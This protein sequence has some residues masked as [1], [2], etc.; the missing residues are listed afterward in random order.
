MASAAHTDLKKLAAAIANDLCDGPDAA[1]SANPAIVAQ[2][3]ER[4]IQ[5]NFRTEEE[6]YAE[7]DKALRALGQT[8]ADMDR[9]KLLAG[10]RERLA[11]QR[12]FIL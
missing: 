8:A 5:V 12:G 11:K 2:V 1:V 9:G 6:I 7:A 10:L 3:V 4:G